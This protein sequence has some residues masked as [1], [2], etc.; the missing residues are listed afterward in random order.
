[1]RDFS[2]RGTGGD[3]RRNCHAPRRARAPV[4]VR[5]CGPSARTALLM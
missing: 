4:F 5:V 1:M 2:A 3:E